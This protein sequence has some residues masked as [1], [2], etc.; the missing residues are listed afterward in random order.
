MH[1]E[2]RFPAESMDLIKNSIRQTGYSKLPLGSRST[3]DKS[4]NE[5]ELIRQINSG[6]RTKSS[7]KV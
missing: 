2:H 5:D 4:V 1:N 3:E 7:G 6:A